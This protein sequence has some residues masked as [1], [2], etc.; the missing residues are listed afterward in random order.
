MRNFTLILASL[1]ALHLA[2]MLSQAENSPTSKGASAPTCAVTQLSAIRT[3]FPQ[4]SQSRGEHGDVLL[5]VSIGKDGRAYASQV[6]HSSGFPLLDK[7]ASDS[8]IQHWRFDV[9]HCATTELPTDSFVTVQFQRPV[10]QTVS[11]TVNTHRPGY[12]NDKNAQSRCDAIRDTSGDQVI[13]CLSN[14]SLADR[15]TQPSLASRS[16]PTATSTS[17]N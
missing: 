7:A 17:G 16:I 3:D 8:V 10:R 14:E 13:A 4:A 15:N 2:P 12:A 1:S 11:G 9:A 5:K 6:A